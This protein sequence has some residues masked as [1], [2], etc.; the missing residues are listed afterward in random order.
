MNPR[1]VISHTVSLRSVV[2]V[3][4]F[5]GFAV[6]LFTEYSDAVVFQGFVKDTP[7][8]LLQGLFAY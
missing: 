8:R 1:G 7:A 5:P 2:R 6:S 3:D 4:T